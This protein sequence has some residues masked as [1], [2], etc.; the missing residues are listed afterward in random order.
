[1]TE[2]EYI[3]KQVAKMTAKMKAAMREAER[4]ANI[5]RST[6]RQLESAERWGQEVAKDRDR[7]AKRCSLLWGK[8]P[9]SAKEELMKDAAQPSPQGAES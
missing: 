6:Q 4:T 2:L 9:D 1:M 3:E 8:L 5:L 7:I